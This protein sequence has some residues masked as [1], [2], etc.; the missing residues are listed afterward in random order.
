MAFF[1][2]LEIARP[3]KRETE[4]SPGFTSPQPG[5]TSEGRKLDE[6]ESVGFLSDCLTPSK[7]CIMGGQKQLGALG[8]DLFSHP[9]NKKIETGEHGIR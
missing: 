8:R 1:L 5:S 4:C 2:A 7:D 6:V 3:E 9:K